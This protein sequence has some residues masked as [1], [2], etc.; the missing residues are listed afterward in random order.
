[1]AVFSVFCGSDE[2]AGCAPAHTKQIMTQAGSVGHSMATMGIDIL[3]GAGYTGAMKAMSQ[4]ALRAGGNVQGVTI[5]RF[6]EKDSQVLA[7]SE[8]ALLEVPAKVCE[9]ATEQAALEARKAILSGD[10]DGFVVLAGGPG[11]L[12][13][14]TM[15]IEQQL[16]AKEQKPVILYDTMG[17]FKPLVE[18]YKKMEQ[19][20]HVGKGKLSFLRHV[21]N[22]DALYKALAPY[23]A[24]GKEPKVEA[25][26]KRHP[27]TARLNF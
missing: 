11:T 4:A 3:Y 1:M 12:A 2:N 24:Q 20:N 19:E 15:V 18:Q 27:V 16:Y 7:D 13:E 22:R 21:T 23:A 17:F 6:F 8:G 25:K 5:P 14:A 26:S 10:A 9:A